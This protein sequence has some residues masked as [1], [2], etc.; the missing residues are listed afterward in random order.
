MKQ[1]RARL[2]AD[3]TAKPRTRLIGHAHPNARIGPGF[4]MADTLEDTVTGERVVLTIETSVEGAARI[5][6]AYAEKGLT[7]AGVPVVSAK[8]T[9][10]LQELC[11]V[12]EAAQQLCDVLAFGICVDGTVS[13]EKRRTF[14]ERLVTL[15]I[16]AEKVCADIEP[17]GEEREGL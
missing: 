4:I 12:E 13:A 15:S 10:S 16:F 7:L 14:C 8:R 17:R 9:L 3:G 2:D 11:E 5:Q 1:P 6:R